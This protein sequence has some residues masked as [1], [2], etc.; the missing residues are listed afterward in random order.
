[1]AFSDFINARERPQGLGGKTIGGTRG[2]REN[3]Q[4]QGN[5]KTEKK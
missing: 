3:K 1:M 4:T 5:K 2:E